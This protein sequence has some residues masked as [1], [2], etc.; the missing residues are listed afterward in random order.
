MS[1]KKSKPKGKHTLTIHFDTKVG[2][3]NFIAQYLN[4]CEQHMEYYSQGWGKDWIYVKPPGGA[5]PKCEFN[6]WGDWYDYDNTDNKVLKVQCSNCEHNYEIPNPIPM[7]NR[8]KNLV[9]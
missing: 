9:K 1:S 6:D 2:I 4:S 7:V 8:P 3:K 5:C